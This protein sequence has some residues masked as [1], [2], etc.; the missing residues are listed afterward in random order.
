M[1]PGAKKDNDEL[2]MVESVLYKSLI[3]QASALE[4]IAAIEEK[5]SG[6]M[7]GSFNVAFG[8][9]ADSFDYIFFG[10]AR[11][12]VE[13]IFHHLSMTTMNICLLELLLK[14]V[15]YLALT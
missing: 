4:K 9:L 6:D 7:R 11:K 10:G 1:T 12:C 8:L 14:M 15:C 13:T 2:H 5:C 3:S